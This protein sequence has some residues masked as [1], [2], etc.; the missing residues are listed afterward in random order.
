[1]ADGSAHVNAVAL[2]ATA[3]ALT[4]D[5]IQF[6][7][8][9]R[10]FGTKRIFDVA[11]SVLLLVV[12]AP[13]IVVVAVAVKLDSRGPLFFRCRRVGFRGRDID[14]LKFRK[15]QDGATGPR[16]TTAGDGRLTRC[17]RVLAA[18]K[19]D[20]LP[21]LWHV[22]IGEMSLVGPRP[23][24][25]AFVGLHVA[26]YE[27]IVQVRPGLTGLSQLAFACEAK[28]LDSDDAIPSYVNRLLPAKVQL[29]LLYARNRT[30]RM[31]LSI[32]AWTVIAVVLRQDVAVNRV[33]GDLT[34]RRRPRPQSSAN[35]RGADVS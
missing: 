10:R 3:S 12:L 20:E 13:L 32:L 14:M 28:L 24:D 21:Q 22:L 7:A 33:S 18:T 6:R 1:M 31:D 5:L 8:P 23:E 17:G 29:D 9:S 27:E 4:D 2:A 11:L 35:K 34:L 25:A 19:L 16:L 30:L 15:M 26:E